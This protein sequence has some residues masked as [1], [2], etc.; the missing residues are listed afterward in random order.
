MDVSEELG[1]FFQTWERMVPAAYN[2]NVQHSDLD[3]ESPTDFSYGLRYHWR[4][5]YRS[6]V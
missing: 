5:G 3:L 6:F 4:M 2:Y 1:S